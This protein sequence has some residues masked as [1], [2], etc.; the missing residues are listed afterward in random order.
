MNAM[1]CG[2][3]TAERLDN[4]LTDRGVVRKVKEVKE[5]KEVSECLSEDVK[6]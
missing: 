4:N 2:F 6:R 1:Q 5:V 3:H